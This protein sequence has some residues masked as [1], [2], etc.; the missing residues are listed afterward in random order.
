MDLL[1]NVTIFSLIWDPKLGNFYKLSVCKCCPLTNICLRKL[2]SFGFQ[3]FTSLQSTF[4]ETSN[5]IYSPGQIIMSMQHIAKLLGAPCC[6]QSAAVMCC[7]MLGVVGLSLKM[8]KFE[9]TTPN[10]AQH[11]TTGWS[12]ACNML[13]PTM[14]DCLAGA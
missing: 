12:N 6:L 1:T 11:S 8:V 3:N 13:R 2:P 14:C 7:D 4:Y 9:P 5:I 10:T